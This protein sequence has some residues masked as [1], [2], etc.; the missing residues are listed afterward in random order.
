MLEV[1]LLNS[2]SLAITARVAVNEKIDITEI[3][4]TM[5]HTGFMDIMD[6]LL[7]LLLNE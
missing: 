1:G 4:D 2:K 5:G 7:F 3:M 6:P